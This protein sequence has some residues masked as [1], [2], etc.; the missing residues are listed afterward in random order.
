MTRMIV[1]VGFIIAFSAGMMTGV[2]WK[3]HAASQP[4]E[5][6]GTP[7]DRGSWLVEQ[8]NLTPDQQKQMKE[9]WSN[10]WP[11]R[12]GP[13]SRGGPDKNAPD[14]KGGP[15]RGGPG[16]RPSFSREREEAIAKLIRPEDRAAYD[17]VIKQ[18]KDKQDAMEAEGRKAFMQAVEKTRAIL[19]P[20]QREKYDMILARH[21]P[22][23]REKDRPTSRPSG[24]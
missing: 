3:G 11:G 16:R 2:N 4:P 17:A 9:I 24:Q 1:I 23:A 19:T 18:F 12:G 8:L 22:D 13:D 10:M 6:Q 14:N 15:D 20:Q 5:Q 21:G 7:R